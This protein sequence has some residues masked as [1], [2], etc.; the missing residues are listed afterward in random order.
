MNTIA[1]RNYGGVA[2]PAIHPNVDSTNTPT[3][4]TLYVRRQSPG[5]PVAL[6]LSVTD[7]CGSW[8][9]IVG[10]GTGAGF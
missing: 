3:S 7:L 10:G 6:P 8:Q 1:V 9:T 5:T 2:T 4:Y